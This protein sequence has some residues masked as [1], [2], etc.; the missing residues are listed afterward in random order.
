MDHPSDIESGDALPL[1]AFRPR[2]VVD[3][4]WINALDPS[5]ESGWSEKFLA[6]RKTDGSPGSLDATD[7]MPSGKLP[8]LLEHMR[9]RMSELASRWIGGDISVTPAMLGTWTPCGTCSFRSVC[10]IEYATRN[11]NRLESMSR[12]DVI[13]RVGRESE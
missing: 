4:D 6:Y 11:L 7:T 10:R 3:F 1:S 9:N 12:G 2:G 13:E 5:F 8:E